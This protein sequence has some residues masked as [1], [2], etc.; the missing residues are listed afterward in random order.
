MTVKETAFQYHAVKALAWRGLK[1]YFESPS[2]YV[3]LTVFYLLTG[4]FFTMPFFYMGQASIKSLADLAPLLFTFLVPALTM[5]L[6]AEELKSGTFENLATLPLEDWDIVLG[7]YL[8]FAGLHLVTIAG[9]LIYPLI[10]AALVNPPLTLDWGETAGV[11]AGLTL[12]GWMFGAIGLYASSLGKNQIVAFV[13]AFLICFLF[14]AGGKLSPSASG[15][16]GRALEFA[17]LD[18]HLGTLSRGVL[19]SRDLVYFTSVALGFLYLAVHRLQMRKRARLFSRTGALLVVAILITLNVL[20]SFTFQRLDFSAGRAY[21]ISPGTKTILKDLKD[22][23]VIKVYFT[24]RLRPPYGLNEQYLRDLLGE[25]KSSGRGKVKVEFLNP[26]G[27]EA[28]KYEAKGAGIPPIRLNILARDK[29]E[30]KEAFMGLAM[31]YNG[32]SAVIPILKDTAEYEHEITKRIKKISAPEVKTVGFVVGHGEKGPG[33]EALR[34]IFQ[35]VNEVMKMEPVTLSSATL[36]QIDALWI[37]GPEKPYS[38]A[39]LERL[40]AWVNSGRSLGILLDRCA[41]DLNGFN[42]RDVNMGLDPLLSAWGVQ[43]MNGLVADVQS[44]KIQLQQRQGAYTFLNIV[45]YPFIPIATKI[46]SD[47][48]ATQSLDAIIFPF[49]HPLVVEPVGT[50]K[51][52]SLID[53][54]PGSWYHTSHSISALAPIKPLESDKKGPFSLAGVLEG[55]FYKV[56]PSSPSHNA[57]GRVILFG[58][59]R[60]IHPSY[61]TK[62]SNIAAFLNLLEWSLQ[63]EALLSIRSRGMS[64]RPL[65]PL[66]ARTRLLIK[67]F[68]LFT[69]PLALVL[70]GCAVYQIQKARRRFLV[71]LYS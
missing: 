38:A 57:P 44:D 27:D 70:A 23:L 14:H 22:N 45:D 51:Y 11:L 33:D 62:A 58:T 5:G 24:P 18:S 6:L 10:L 41:V 37:V 65:R 52:T 34:P 46:N 25:Y 32:K 67:Y 8:S 29:L 50:L 55:D 28:V 66:Q 60:M 15:F 64:Y 3:A 68:M 4:Y 43:P 2:A 69:L 31:L 16:L 36:P 54:S 47:H 26:E 17:G 9:L 21:S 59:S 53:S 35:M 48:P 42:T 40:K 19:D 61:S 63:D 1:A 13:I 39:E 71:S 49:V 20:S 56:T 12:I 7:K 30:I